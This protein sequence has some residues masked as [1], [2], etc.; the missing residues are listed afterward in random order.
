[1]KEYIPV[2]V[3]TEIDEFG[4][5]TPKEIVWTNERRYHIQRVI[6]VC[7]PEDKVIRYTIL[8]ADTQRQLFYN[9]SEWRISTPA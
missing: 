7:Q 2:D 5:E 1:M 6:Q 9:G 8:I 3:I 4:N